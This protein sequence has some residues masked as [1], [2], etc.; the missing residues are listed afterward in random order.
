M[1]LSFNG[2]SEN[3]ITFEADTTLTKAGVPVKVEQDGKVALAT[4]GDRICGVAVNVREGF[5]A[6]QLRGYMEFPCAQVIPC[7]F[8][9][10]GADAQGNL[11]LA[12]EGTEVLVVTSKDDKTGFIL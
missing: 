12:D 11:V 2:F 7:G 6:V 8:Q 9:K 10:I 1:N 3:T 5:A 4:T